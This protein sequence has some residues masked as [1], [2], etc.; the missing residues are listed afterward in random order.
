MKKIKIRRP[1]SDWELSTSSTS[2]SHEAKG[3]LGYIVHPR[4]C[5]SI[6][7]FEMCFSS[8]K[9]NSFNF[10]WSVERVILSM[11]SLVVVSNQ[12]DYLA[13][14]ILLCWSDFVSTRDTF[15]PLVLISILLNLSKVHF[16][17]CNAQRIAVLFALG[18]QQ[19]HSK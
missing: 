13:H 1:A 7:C 8:L 4:H 14:T 5:S 16:T 18:T 6:Q 17:L 9:K 12:F 3:S 15:L 2:C 11:K 19:G 10:F